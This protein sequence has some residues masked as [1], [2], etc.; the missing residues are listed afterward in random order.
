[1]AQQ[2]VHD[3]PAL[4]VA[5]AGYCLQ[6]C[7]RV[8][9]ETRLVAAGISGT[10]AMSLAAE[11]PGCCRGLN[12]ACHKSVRAASTTVLLQYL[13]TIMLVSFC[14]AVAAAV[15][16]LP[17]NCSDSAGNCTLAHKAPL[18]LGTQSLLAALLH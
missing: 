6:Q 15:S 18:G 9:G 11:Q 12:A 17:Q 3:D 10:K 1:L 5:A 4:S 7:L 13:L 2:A 8:H 16:I 14:A